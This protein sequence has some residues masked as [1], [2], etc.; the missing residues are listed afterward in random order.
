MIDGKEDG[1]ARKRKARDK[2]AHR[3]IKQQH[4]IIPGFVGVCFIG[5]V[6]GATIAMSFDAGWIVGGA[7]LGTWLGLLL[8]ANYILKDLHK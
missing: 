4:F 5:M 6:W 2:A 8:G 1:F 3:F 7:L